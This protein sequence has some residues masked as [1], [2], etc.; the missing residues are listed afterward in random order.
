MYLAS[1]KTMSDYAYFI[2]DLVDEGK[3]KFEES[4]ETY[5]RA[6]WGLILKHKNVVPSWMLFAYLVEEAFYAAPTPFSEEWIIYA[7]PPNLDTNDPNQSFETLQKMI[8]YQIAELRLMKANGT[9]DLPGHIL[10]M[11]VV[12]PSGHGWYNFHPLSFL[13]QGVDPSQ[14]D[15]NQVQCDWYDLAIILWL[16]Q[17]YE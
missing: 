3:I 7:K 15:K 9:L 11:G 14:P 17:I 5:L 6:L 10:F 4:L 13:R 12:G 1:V 2:E 16:G 8:L